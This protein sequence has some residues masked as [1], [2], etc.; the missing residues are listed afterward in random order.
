[1]TETLTRVESPPLVL[2]LRPAIELSDEQFFAFCRLNPDLRIERTAEGDVE[3]M[4]PAGGR[5]GNRN[6]GITAQLW[7]W[8]LRDGT[9]AAFDAATGFILPNGAVRAPDAAWVHMSR[10]QGLTE[11]QK[12]R[13]MPLCPDFAIELRSPSDRLRAAQA[14]MQEYIENGAAMGWLIDTANRRI[15]VYRPGTKVERQDEPATL[16]GDPELPGFVLDLKLV[17]EARF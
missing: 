4:S 14:K 10:L 15:Y 6:A 3:I 8:A 2:H 1:M 9:G 5:T 13:F 11:E 12:E 7:T 17:W 16:S